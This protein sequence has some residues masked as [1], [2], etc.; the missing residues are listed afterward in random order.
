MASLF[1]DSDSDDE[2]EEG[3]RGEG[4]V[5]NF[6]Y[7]DGDDDDG[8]AEVDFLEAVNEDEDDEDDDDALARARTQNRAEFLSTTEIRHLTAAFDTCD[9]TGTGELNFSDFM[10][11]L[12]VMGKKVTKREAQKFFEAMDEDKSGFIS[13]DEWVS[14]Y[15]NNMQFEVDEKELLNSFI[16]LWQ[17][18]TAQHPETNHRFEEEEFIPKEKLYEIMTKYGEKLTDEE[19]AEMIRECNPD[20]VGRIF[21]ENYRHMLIDG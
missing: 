14:F 2:D 7:E 15:A 16:G 9:K 13:L 10:K 12:S 18:P 8:E 5:D 3:V 4:G 19:A 17:Q 21:F 20:E 11:C 6:L 1:V